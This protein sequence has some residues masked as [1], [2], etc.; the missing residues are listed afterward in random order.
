MESKSENRQSNAN[1]SISYSKIILKNKKLITIGECSRFY[2]LL[3]G[4]T[5]CKLISIFILSGLKNNVGIF[6]F[7]PILNSYSIMQ[8]IYTYIGYIFFGFIFRFIGK[9]KKRINRRASKSSLIHKNLSSPNY[10]RIYFQIFLVSFCFGFYSEILNILYG[11]GFHSL[12][13][14]TFETVFTFILMKKYFEIDIYIHQKCSIYFIV[15]TSSIFLLIA[16]LMPDSSGLNTYQTIEARFGNYYYS[17][18]II[19]SFIFLSYIF[20]FS[21]TFSKVLMQKKNLSYF[22]LIALIGIAGLVVALISNIIL[23]NINSDNNISKYFSDLNS[24]DKDYKYYLEIF[25]IYPLFI[26]I[27][28]MLMYFEI[29][30]IYYLNPIYAL[31]TNNLT[32]GSSNIVSLISNNSSNFLNFLFSEL[33]EIF[34]LFG[35]IFYLEILELNFC[36]LSDNVKRNIR[37][38]G[39][40]E[41]NQLMVE[42]IQ[43]IKAL[44]DNEVEEDEE[45]E[46]NENNLEAKKNIEMRDKTNE[47]SE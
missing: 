4:A 9:R 44:Y 1:Y 20:G 17:I 13:Y 10:K 47:G 29:L 15:I 18:I 26:F 34:A 2:F 40:N 11:Q 21:R 32:Y 7:S 6:G 8:S 33:S 5:I 16:S 37:S 27:K 36:G 42:R 28:F 41:F 25:L 23:Y 35:Y 45:A 12:N 3:L 39:E 43:T 31:A 14:W 22:L 38:K 19:L 30:I 46:E 24:I